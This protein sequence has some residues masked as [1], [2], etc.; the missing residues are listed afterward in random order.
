MSIT[1]YS[2]TSTKGEIMLV[3][4]VRAGMVVISDN[5]FRRCYIGYTKSDA[6]RR[7]K[8][9]QKMNARNKVKS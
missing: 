3:N 4:V 1:E 7:F 2:K 9:L 6:I 5:G 8:R